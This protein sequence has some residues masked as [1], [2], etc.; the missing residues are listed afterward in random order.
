MERNQNGEWVAVPRNQPEAATDN[1]V[2]ARV[3]EAADQTQYQLTNPVQNAVGGQVNASKT[4]DIFTLKRWNIDLTIDR[5]QVCLWVLIMIMKIMKMLAVVC[6][7]VA[8]LFFLKS[9]PGWE[10]P[11]RVI[12]GY[13]RRR[14]LLHNQQ[15]IPEGDVFW[16]D[17]FPHAHQQTSYQIWIEFAQDAFAENNLFAIFIPIL[18]SDPI[19]CSLVAFFFFLVSHAVTFI[20]DCLRQANHA[21]RTLAKRRR[22]A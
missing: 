19:V 12:N 8:A 11:Q 17:L 20:H 2:V 4:Y 22:T 9:L 15:V 6:F 5:V 18:V 14:D 10:G 16:A 1:Q 3:D 7:W 21:T 13:V